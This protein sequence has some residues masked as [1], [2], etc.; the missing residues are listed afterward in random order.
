MGQSHSNCKDMAIC[1]VIFNPARTRRMIMNYLYIKNKFDT[2]KLPNFT[3]ELIYKDRQPEI[4]D[5]FHVHSN[6]V[7]FHKENLY[8]VL[9]KKIPKKYKK[10][11]FL[12]CDVMFEDP[13]WYSKTS[14]LLDTHDI[15]QPFETAYWLDLTYTQATLSR[16]TVLHMKNKKWDFAYHPGFAWC[17]RRD[18]YNKVGFFDYALSGSGDTLSSAVWLD[19]YFPP[20]FQSL[21]KALVNEYKKYQTSPVP[22]ITFLKDTSIHHLYHGSRENRQYSERHKMLNI[23]EDVKELITTNKDGVFEWK[24]PKNW[25]SIFLNYFVS[26]NDDDLGQNISVMITS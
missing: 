16:K 1:F 18:W 21:P 7:M 15:V 13:E 22:R 2:Q 25:N 3:I 12:D 8:R 5:A 10:L 9:E 20:N 14:K 24:E 6:S 19:K 26:R 4:P 17:M 11:A 23:N